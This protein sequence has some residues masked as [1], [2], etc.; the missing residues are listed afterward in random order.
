[1]I[2]ELFNH[3]EKKVEYIEL[4][5]DLIFVYIIGRSNNMLRHVEG[6]FI[7]FET[8]FIY[9][10]TTLIILQIWFFTVLFINRYGTNGAAEYLGLFIN[11]YLLYYMAQGTNSDWRGYYT[12]FNVSWALILVNLAVQYLLKLRQCPG[13]QPEVRRHILYHIALLLSGAVIVGL[14]IPVFQATGLALSPIAM[15]AG[16]I[17]T[18]TV[19]K[20]IYRSVPVDFPHLS[21]RV[22]LY[23][24]FTF[25]EMIISMA[26]YFEGGFSPN[27]VYFSLMGFLIVAGLFFIYGY[28]YDHVID[29]EGSTNGIGYMLIHILLITM[30]NNIT[31]ALEFMREPEIDE[32]KK[33][34]FLVASFALYFAFL[35]LTLLF[36]KKRGDKRGRF[37]L[38][39]CGMTVCFAVLM[40]A[41]Y[42]NSKISIAITVVYIYAMLLTNILHDRRKSSN[43]L[44]NNA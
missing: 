38:I 16:V 35:A 34:V 10:L 7:P 44:T 36:A 1:M 9:L 11:M 19:G 6:G 39:T 26:G 33:H 22:M 2:K 13:K 30:L 21:E 15:V 4:I 41:L 25:G 23:V 31:I 27:S 32:V 3:E 37:L 29:R 8:Y 20:G 43:D 18:M 5:Y 42:R 40:A 12:Q 28:Y 17:I 24:V 14:S